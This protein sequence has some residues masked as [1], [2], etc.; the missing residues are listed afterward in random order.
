MFQRALTVI[1]MSA[2]ALLPVGC[3]A[4]TMS[5]RIS[6]AS[7]SLAEVNTLPQDKKPTKQQMKD[8]NPSQ[9]MV[10]KG[11]ARAQYAKVMAV[12]EIMKRVDITDIGLVT[13]RAGT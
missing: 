13:T 3:G 1:V 9:A 8:A 2:L 12:L 10:I 5:S 7:L 11:D 6:D 4:S